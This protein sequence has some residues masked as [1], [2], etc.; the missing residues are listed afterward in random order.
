MKDINLVP[1]YVLHE[2]K[3]LEM[4][5]RLIVWGLLIAVVLAA[6]GIWPLVQKALLQAEISGLENNIKDL[7][8]VKDT[9]E[10]LINLINDMN[11]KKSLLAKVEEKE[12]IAQDLM[13]KL[14]KLTPKTVK[15]N[16]LN[17]KSDDGSVTMAGVGSNEF[18][19]S[20]FIYNLRTDG[21]FEGMFV[22]ALSPPSKEGSTERAFNISFKY[23]VTGGNK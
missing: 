2:R 23:L 13:A 16:S 3:S 7:R 10:R 15:I 5:G 17:Y 22:P 11:R 9:N 6:A 1:H 8:S 20:D 18:A 21:S 19:I 4:K 12:K 14:E